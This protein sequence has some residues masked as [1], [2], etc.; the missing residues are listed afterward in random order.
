MTDLTR[1]LRH[2]VGASFYESVTKAVDK[3]HSGDLDDIFSLVSLWVQNFYKS[4]ET[5]TQLGNASSLFL[6][7][8][9]GKNSTHSTTGASLQKRARP[10]SGQNCRALSLT[11]LPNHS[12]IEQQNGSALL[13]HERIE[14]SLKNKAVT[15]CRDLQHASTANMCDSR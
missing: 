13:F 2:T 12:G 8:V 6:L 5:H 15:E 10:Q 7:E 3:K 11:Q 9:E 14:S 1:Y 4:T